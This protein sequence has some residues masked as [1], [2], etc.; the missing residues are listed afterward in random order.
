[1]DIVL[2]VTAEDGKTKATYTIK[3]STEAASTGGGSTEWH[4]WIQNATDRTNN[5]FKTNTDKFTGT[6]TYS[7][8]KTLDKQYTIALDKDYT[9]K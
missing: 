6:S 7:S 8:N 4:I 2:E 9:L 5:G 3:V 1:M